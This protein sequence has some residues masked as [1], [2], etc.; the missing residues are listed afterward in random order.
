MAR[1][2]EAARKLLLER[3]V[4]PADPRLPGMERELAG[5]LV[6]DAFRAKREA[7]A[8]REAW[9]RVRAAQR[10]DKEPFRWNRD[11]HRVGRGGYG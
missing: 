8:D 1:N 9:R 3:G 7:I 5:A 6:R 11:G 2:V 4:L 10:D